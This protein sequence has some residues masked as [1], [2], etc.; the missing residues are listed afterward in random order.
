[1]KKSEKERRIVKA[2]LNVFAHVEIVGKTNKK[3]YF[4]FMLW[5][6][7]CAHCSMWVTCVYT[8]GVTKLHKNFLLFL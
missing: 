3:C 8:Y 6:C 2:A 4:I 7:V 5:F 1:M